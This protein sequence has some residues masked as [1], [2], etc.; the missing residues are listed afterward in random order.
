MTTDHAGADWTPINGSTL[1]GDHINV[2]TFTISSGYTCNIA[3]G[4]PFKLFANLINLHG[5]IDG[6]GRGYYGGGSGSNGAGP[7]G[8]YKGSTNVVGAGGGGYGGKGGDGSGTNPPG[9]GGIANGPSDEMSIDMGSGGAGGS[10]GYGTVGGGGAGGGAVTLCGD[11]IE[12]FPSSLI[13][14]YGAQGGYADSPGGGGA[15][16][17]ILLVCNTLICE[18]GGCRTTGG[19]GATGPGSCGGGAGSG[20]RVKAIYATTNNDPL[21]SMSAMG[22]IASGTGQNGAVGTEYG[23]QTLGELATSQPVGQIFN[24]GIAGSVV[25]TQVV[26]KAGSYTTAGACTLTVYNNSTKSITYGS[27]LNIINSTLEETWIFTT[28]IELP[29]GQLDYYMELTTSA[30]VCTMAYSCIN[31]FSNYMH[32]EDGEAVGVSLYMKLYIYSHVINPVIY[33]VDDTSTKCYVANKV[34]T[35]ASHQINADGTGHIHYE[36]DF[37]TSKFVGDRLSVG[38]ETYD[39]VNNLLYLTIG[40]H[41]AYKFDCKY[42]IVGIPIISSLIN[43][44]VETVIQI[45]KDVNGSPGVWYNINQEIS[46]FTNQWTRR[47]LDSSNLHVEGKTILYFRIKSISGGAYIYKFNL[48]INIDTTSA[49]TLMMPANM[50]STFQ[51]D[52]MS[53]SSINCAVELIQSD[54][55]Y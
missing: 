5:T 29:D 21:N 18:F 3:Q 37:T 47:G 40:G 7:G 19:S 39:T 51:I 53:S 27:A 30:A 44:N 26:L 35:G 46:S 14:C 16:G 52:Q 54:C 20:G 25:M 6:D 36:D 41:V 49:Q 31:N 38:G 23:C 10:S 9:Y 4:V 1:M 33:N 32:Y 34:L 45:A 50:I 43:I 11:K 13:T 28:P 55:K 17:G 42:P 24:F 15:G 8:G 22:G 2:G 48:D 12:F